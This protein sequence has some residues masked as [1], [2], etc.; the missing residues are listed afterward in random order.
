[1]NSDYL[2]CYAGRDRTFDSCSVLANTQ[3]R[4]FVNRWCC[5]RRHGGIGRIALSFA[6]AIG[7]I[8]GLGD[9]VFAQSQIVPDRTLGAESSQVIPNVNNLPVEVINGGAIRGANLFHSFEEFNIAQGRRAFFFSP[10]PT[11]QNILARITGRNPSQILGILG[12]FGNSNPNLF[13]INPNGLIFGPN[14]RLSIGGS[15]IASTASN[16]VFA[17]GTLFQA[18]PSQPSPLLTISVPIGLQLKLVALL[19]TIWSI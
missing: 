19:A 5:E 17:D 18:T 14:A 12:T 16:V 8:G 11:I 2:G 6:S 15:F 4:R 10:S 9:N 3:S 1:M 13:L 7:I